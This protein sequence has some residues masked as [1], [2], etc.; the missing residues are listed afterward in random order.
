MT[1]LGYL[2]E[3]GFVEA[4]YAMS[5]GYSGNYISMGNKGVLWAEVEV[6]GRSAHGSTPHKGVNSFERMNAIVNELGKLKSKILKRKTRYNM[7]DTISKKPSFVMGGFLEGGVKVNVIP[8]MTKFS[9]DRRLIP[10]ENIEIAKKEIEG[11]IKKFNAR[12][13][14]KPPSGRAEEWKERGSS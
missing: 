10:E 7:R 3:K 14:Q 9:I 12:Y 4:D 11:V 6:M 8:G 2:V 5:E 1:G 13:K